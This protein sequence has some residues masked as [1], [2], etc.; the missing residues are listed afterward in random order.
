MDEVIGTP[1]VERD[2]ADSCNENTLKPQPA[3]DKF[4]SLAAK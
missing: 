3:S 2:Q 4:I 1:P